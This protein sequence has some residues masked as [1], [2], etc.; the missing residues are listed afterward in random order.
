MASAPEA[1]TVLSDANFPARW[2]K[3]VPDYA[4]KNR[5]DVVKVK[6]PPRFIKIG[7][8]AFW[9]CKNL[10]ECFVPPW[11]KVDKYAFQGCSKLRGTT[12]L[13]E[14]DFPA[15]WGDSIPD[16][17]FWERLDVVKVEL[18]SRIKKIGRYAFWGCSN[19]E[20][21]VVPL[22]VKVGEYALLGCKK[23]RG[24]TV[25]SDAYFPAE[26]G[27]TVP[28]KAFEDRVDV[29]KVELPS[30]IKKIGWDAFFGCNNLEECV[31]PP[32]VEVGVWA[33]KGCWK[34]R[35]TTVL[36]DADFPAEWGDTVPDGAFANHADVVK[37][38]LPPRIKKIDKHAFG[39]C[40]NLEE[41]VI[42]PGVEV[43]MYAFESCPK[44]RGTNV[45]G[46]SDFP[47]K[48][49]DTVPESAFEGR[50]DIVKVVIPHRFKKIGDK[51][52]KN[53][54]NLEEFFVPPGI[55][56]GNHSF[57]MCSSKF[58]ATTVLEDADFPAAWGDTVPVKAFENR[59]DVCKVNLP[60]RIKIIGEEAFRYCM[61][62]K[63]FNIKPGFKKFSENV[64]SCCCNL[65]ECVVPPGVEVGRGTFKDCRDLR[66]T[67]VLGEADFP[68]EWGDTV[69]DEAFWERL[70]LLKVVLPVRI[71]K[72]GKE[73]FGGCW[74]LEECVVPPFVEVGRD[75]F[76][77]C[78]EL[79]PTTVLDDA[80]FPTEWGDTIPDNAFENRLDV[81]K[82][83]IPSRIKNIGK[84]AFY[85]CA[86]LRE[87][88]VPHGIEKIEEEAFCCC[89]NLTVMVLPS[90][91]HTIAGEKH[92][93]YT[94]GAF[95]TLRKLQVLAL[96]AG[97][98]KLGLY[99]FY[100]TNPKILVVPPSLPNDV[101]TTI[102]NMI[103][104]P[105]KK[106][107]FGL[108]PIV[109]LSQ[110]VQMIGPKT[111]DAVVAALQGSFATYNNMAEVPQ[112]R[113]VSSSLEYWYWT[114]N[115][116]QHGLGTSSQRIAVRTVLFVAGRFIFQNCESNKD[117][118][119]PSLPL[120]P[121]QPSLPY[122]MWTLILG[123]I[124]RDELGLRVI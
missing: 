50:R 95:Q 17:A 106:A 11:V 6:I 62:L 86:K 92:S 33:F 54:K 112:N 79:K 75:A 97:L 41:C 85:D 15:E 52:F 1:T 16:E 9:K 94:T 70:D 104:L 56:V 51:A 44:L 83:E 5:D 114:R 119:P 20:E 81:V 40:E 113:I 38:E 74:N 123:W 69:P 99:A 98:K 59:L 35:A 65:E 58:R 117:G 18:P 116:H 57:V 107:Y 37:V 105:S 8:M 3:T 25:L 101:V 88:V 67:T 43:G 7:K 60:S 90:T 12:V 121:S 102:T 91:V 111:P 29:V 122:K 28:D 61:N 47:A 63:E 100:D 84:N 39:N 26:W 10:E 89:E 4:F 109:S 72:L 36:G 32:G 93:S 64:F 82:V 66:G 42:P 49:G 2:G 73:A 78:V 45:L 23:L 87:F 46:D 14:A 30:R 80:D 77:Y 115:T 34:L 31:V 103:S 71:K 27:D 53:C 21:C 96:P 118:T 124:R 68:A 108:D 55:K 76:D 22:G 120:P 13:G 24:T 110:S 19:L 48:W